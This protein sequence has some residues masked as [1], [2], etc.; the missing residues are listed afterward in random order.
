MVP[1]LTAAERIRR[2]LAEKAR[3]EGLDEQL[4]VHDERLRALYEEGYLPGRPISGVERANFWEKVRERMEE[5]RRTSTLAMS[6]LEEI[7]RGLEVPGL[8]SRN[9]NV[10]LAAIKLRLARQRAAPP[11]QVS[12]AS[13]ALREKF[14]LALEERRAALREQLARPGTQ[15]RFGEHIEARRTESE[16]DPR[17]E[18]RS[19]EAAL[20]KLR[21]ER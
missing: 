5:L 18:M 6:G 15:S 3:A 7:E 17:A 16:R 13:R 19:I 11:N 1:L 21:E 20:A 4:V 2:A 9:G 14:V 10:L 12:S 8:L